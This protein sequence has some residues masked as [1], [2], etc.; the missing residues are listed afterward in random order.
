MSQSLS[1]GWIVTCLVG[2]SLLLGGC[3]SESKM[4]GSRSRAAAKPP[5]SYRVYVGTYTGP[6]KG[7]GIYLFDFDT[8]SGALKE[9]GLVAETA[10][11]SFLALAPDERFLYADGEIDNF[12]GGG[13]PA[14]A[15]SAFSVDKSNGGLALL[16]QQASGGAG[17]CHV[18]ITS[19]ARTVMVAN[20]G[21][22]SVASYP[23]LPDGKLGEAASVIQHTGKGTDPGRQE[24]PHAHGIYPAPGDSFVLACDLG[25]DKV[26]IYRRNSKTSALTLQNNFGEVPPGGGARH[27]TFSPD[28]KFFYV[29]NEMGNTVTA[30]KWDGGM[31]TLKPIQTVGTLPEGFA[32]KSHTAEIFA[33]PSG[34]FVYGSNRGHDSIAVF[35]V[36]KGTGKLALADVTPIGGK[37][38]RNFNL[39]PT[40]QWL[41]AAGERSDTLT[42]F[43]V[44]PQTGKLTPAGG[45]VKCPAPAC[46]I[47]AKK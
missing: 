29:I 36:D 37:W 28:G 39:D 42:V 3:R 24:G 20:Y 4:S 43:K 12:G 13:K 47:F 14:G 8:A 18:S 34:K 1:A 10:S 27:G 44:D 40:G 22:G 9:V 46:V 41:I 15:V 2:A 11:P 45:P 30:F 32:G 33:H 21:G 7:K 26:L 6:N 25:L 5:A 35:T 19:D 23:V 38:P 31:G 16:N 17:P